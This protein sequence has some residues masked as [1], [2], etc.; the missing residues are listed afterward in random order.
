MLDECIPTVTA[1]VPFECFQ[2]AL[3]QLR[4]DHESNLELLE[5][6]QERGVNFRGILFPNVLQIPVLKDSLQE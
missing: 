2:H 4:A 1:T 6:I 3:L 5:E